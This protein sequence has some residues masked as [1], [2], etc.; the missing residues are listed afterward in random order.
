MWAGADQLCGCRVEYVAH[1][2]SMQSLLLRSY[3]RAPQP[4]GLPV[5]P[6]ALSP[7]PRPLLMMKKWKGPSQQQ[8]CA[9]TSLCPAAPM[10]LLLMTA[11]APLPGPRPWPLKVSQS[12]SSPLR[13][14]CSCFASWRVHPGTGTGSKVVL[15]VE[16]TMAS[17]VVGSLYTHGGL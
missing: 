10:L 1:T 15:S 8:G 12:Q 2:A 7:L 3:Q 16:D 5:P 6:F 17:C 11:Q 13:A 9:T 4:P 14:V